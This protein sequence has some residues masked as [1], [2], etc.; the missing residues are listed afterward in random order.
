MRR[1]ITSDRQLLFIV[2]TLAILGF[3]IFLSASMGLLARGTG[4]SFGSVV[5]SQGVLGLLGGF[6]AMYITAQIPYTFWRKYS[7]YVFLGAILLTILV[8]IPGIGFAHGGASRWINL[9]PISFQ[10]SEFLKIAFII[11]FAAWL[12]GVWRKIGNA[13]FG[14]IPFGILLGIIGGILLLQPDTDTFLVIFASGIAMYITAG[15][16]WRDVAV[17]LLASALG[18]AIIAFARPY[19]MDRFLTFLDPSRDPLGSGYQIQQSLIAVGSGGFFGRGFGQS[20][21]KFDFLPEPIG[22]SVF[23]VF[24]EEFGF[25]GGVLLILLFIWF[26]K[27]GLTISVRAPDTF[28]RLLVLGIVILI[29][30]Q[31]VI[32]IGSMLSV[33]PLTGIPLPFVSHGG[34]ALFITLA[35][36]GIILNISKHMK[37]TENSKRKTA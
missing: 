6:I 27:R 3:F 14:L 34:T 21:Q 16:R 8:F 32:N 4:A 20:V 1:F 15:A 31:A 7:F 18:L 23:A 37:K 17:M 5:F 22:D 2:A 10:P 19:V 24:A 36:I 28:S 25:L 29:V 26:A 33:L 30:T 12:S 11:Y 9:G 13:K 35:E